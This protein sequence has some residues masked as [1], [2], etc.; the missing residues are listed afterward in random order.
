MKYLGALL[1]I[2]AAGVILG[3]S[4][5]KNSDDGANTD[6][7]RDSNSDGMDSD[8]TDSV[9]TDSDGTD[10]E[11]MQDAGSD[12]ESTADYD[13]EFEARAADLV[14]QMTLEEKVSQMGHMAFSIPRLGVASYNWWNEALHGVARSGIATVFPQSISMAATFDPDLLFEESTVISTE[15]RVKNNLDN[16]GLTY[17]SPTINLARD[18][19]WGRNEE[20][21]GEDPYLTSR[22]AVAF[23]RGMQ[24]DDHKY[25]KTVSTLKHFAANNIEATRHTGS[26][27]V[28][29]RNLREFYFPAF[30]AGIEEGRA[31][32]VMC[33]YN[34]VNGIPSCANSWMLTDVLRGEWGFKGY[35]VSDCWAIQDI[36]DGHAYASSN[37]EASQMALAA[38]T[39][40]ECGDR[41]QAD[42]V[43]AVQ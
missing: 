35:V 29:E 36:V 5:S 9:R 10:S 25:L 31:Q 4:N 41:Y 39:N 19:R 14:A 21:Y 8:G 27:D 23:V 12:T 40:L 37:V 38:G 3:C 13:A 18:P 22:M 34:A 1:I 42:L 20:T 43:Y 2:W 30:K 17:W 6:E 26:S 16:K 15:A 28:D 7:Q 11:T 24:G 33:S 32:S